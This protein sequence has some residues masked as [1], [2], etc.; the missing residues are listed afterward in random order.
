MKNE[1]RIESKSS[2]TAAYTC[3]CR[4]ASYIEKDPLLRSGDYIA[5]QL[6]PRFVKILTKIRF[7]NLKGLLSPKGIYPYVIA[8]TK[9]L[10]DIVQK[11]LEEGVRQVVIMG[12][13][14][15]SRGIRFSREKVK[16]FEID[17]RHTQEAKLKQYKKRNI[18]KPADNILIPVN[19]EKENPGDKLLEYG[20]EKDIRTLFIL[21]GITMYLS[22]EAIEDIFSLVREFSG[23]DSL[24]VFDYIYASVLR[25]ENRYYGEK[26][27][28]SRVKKD[29]EGWTFG[30]EENGLD[31]FLS[32]QHFKRLEHL[33]A[34][35]LE[36]RYFTNTSGKPVIRAN[37]THCVVLAQNAG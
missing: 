35:A 1:R 21:E 37:G 17:T 8:R 16:F 11:M 36:K 13:G 3:M 28:Y 20:F 4:A 24:I 32:G 19:F 22:V 34:Q 26:A 30:I 31:D 5:F 23:P 9:Y 10:D 33:D 18:T 25:K 7:L 2:R 6:L 15:D 12:A 29:G 14:F 27:I